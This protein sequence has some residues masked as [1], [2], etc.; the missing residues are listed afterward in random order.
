ME[1]RVERLRIRG[2]KTGEVEPGAFDETF[3]FPLGVTVI[4]ADNLRGKTSILEMATL[5]LRGEL[6]NLQADVLSWL[7]AVSLDVHINGEPIGFRLSL[8][9]SEITSGLILAGAEASL[10]ASDDA[11]A[12]G[13]TELARVHTSEEWAEQVGSFMMTRL[14]LEEM[15]VFNKARSADESGTIRSHGWPAYFSVLYP[16]SGADTVLLGSTPSD[17]LPVRLMQVF[18][19]MPEATRSMRISALA[20]RLDSELKAGQ[21]RDKDA[22][23]ALAAQVK[24][25]LERLAAAKRRVSELDAAAP[26][27]SLKELT[28]WCAIGR[29][30]RSE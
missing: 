24:A 2:R 5:I 10:A 7:S 13:V 18:L 21:R 23:T 28:T 25:A 26:A 9:G 14:G 8:E 20:K 29:T 16:P 15:Q 12:D 4:S 6:R 11:R 3:T 22:S 30:G 17:F 1:T 19:D 27:E